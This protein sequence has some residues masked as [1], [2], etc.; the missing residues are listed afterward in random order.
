MSEKDEER[1]ILRNWFMQLW[2]LVSP[3]SAVEEGK[4]KSA[5]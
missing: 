1:F 4:S 2:R 5:G 3:I